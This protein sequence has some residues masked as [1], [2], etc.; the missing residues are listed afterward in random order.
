[1]QIKK[2][3]ITIGLLWCTTFVFSQT[4]TVID[5]AT[6]SS[7]NCDIFNPSVN[8]ASKTHYTMFGQ[9]TY[10]G[11]DKDVILKC[12]KTSNGDKKTGYKILFN[13]KQGYSYKIIVNTK[14]KTAAVF[15]NVYDEIGLTL[16][17][18]NVVDN[19][20]TANCSGA[21]PGIAVNDKKSPSQGSYTDLEWNFNNLTTS[22]SVLQV[23]TSNVSSPIPALNL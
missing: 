20:G 3:L 22:S 12:D 23:I 10:N 16:S 6:F 14:N 15:G 17:T 7:N 9:P 2:I 5:Y 8:F 13:F 18:D 4:Q 1:M 19:R 11:T 21:E